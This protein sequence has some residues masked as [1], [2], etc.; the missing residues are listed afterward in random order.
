MKYI[1]LFESFVNELLHHGYDEYDGMTVIA[2]RSDIWVVDEDNISDFADEI[3]AKLGLSDISDPLELLDKY[4]QNE[5]CS[6]NPTIVC[7]SIQSRDF[8]LVGCNGLRHSKYSTDVKKIL[9]ELD[10]DDVVVEYQDPTDYDADVMTHYEFSFEDKK[11]LSTATFYHGTSF[12]SIKSILRT[13]IAPRKLTGTKTNYTNIEHRELVFTTVNKE[14][15]MGHAYTAAVEKNSFPILIEHGLPDINKLDL[16]FD[17]A[18]TYY[19]IE[20]NATR[21]LGYNRITHRDSEKHT[22]S[23]D[24]NTKLGK[25]SYQGRIPA[26]FIKYIYVDNNALSEYFASQE[27]LVDFELVELLDADLSSWT[28]ISSS[29]FWNYCNRLR[30]EAIDQYSDFYEDED[31]N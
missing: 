2:Y 3:I 19:G 8:Y 16:D 9:K 27:D 23:N 24:I 31:Y 13:G 18:V 12:D 14:Q 17:V 5:I 28:R 1:K 10:L 22:H 26:T 29:D 21:K 6:E 20:H 15:A 11:K 7:G 4:R 25:F 30:K